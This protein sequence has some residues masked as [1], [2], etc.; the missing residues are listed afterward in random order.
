MNSTEKILT[1][2]SQK[3]RAN[4]FSGLY[5]PGGC[6]C[7]IDDLAPCCNYELGPSE[8]YINGCCAGYK[9]VDPRSKFGDFA[10]TS[11]QEPPTDEEFDAYLS[12]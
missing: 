12:Y 5:Y 8:E 7:G 11:S 6:G 1:Y 3:L 10:I 2:V 4:G 9:H